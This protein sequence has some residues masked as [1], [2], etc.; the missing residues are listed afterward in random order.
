[1]D[2]RRARMALWIT[3]WVLAFS[4][5]KLLL[6]LAKNGN[7]AETKRHA[8]W[9]KQPL[10]IHGEQLHCSTWR[11]YLLVVLDIKQKSVLVWTWRTLAK[12]SR[13]LQ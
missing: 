3:V 10:V 9:R 4:G 12:I 8:T 6:E 5:W 1:M 13:L 7:G 11:V 2:Y